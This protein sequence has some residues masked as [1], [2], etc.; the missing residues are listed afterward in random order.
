MSCS[1]TRKKANTTWRPWRPLVRC[2]LLIRF[3]PMHGR[4]RCRSSAVPVRR[5]NP[6]PARFAGSPPICAA[7]GRRREVTEGGSWLAVLLFL[8]I[9]RRGP[10]LPVLRSCGLTCRFINHRAV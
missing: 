8:L 1:L 10:C 7:Q 5:R 9:L 6:V 2:R 4:K 3:G